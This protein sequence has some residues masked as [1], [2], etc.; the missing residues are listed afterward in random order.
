M[1]TPIQAGV[2]MKNVFSI[3][4]INLDSRN[5]ALGNNPCTPYDVCVKYFAGLDAD[6]VHW[7]QSYFCDGKPIIEQFLRQASLIP[8]KPI[9]V[10]SESQTGNWYVHNNT[11][12]YCIVLIL[13][14][15]LLLG[16][17]KTARRKLINMLLTIK[18]MNY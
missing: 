6:I 4:D 11:I 10:F 3:L 16:Q 2:I 5:V 12:K 18:K 15:L 14:A 13:F 17:Q 7:E 8:S 9:V 1:S